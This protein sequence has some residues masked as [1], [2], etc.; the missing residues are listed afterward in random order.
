MPGSDPRNDDLTVD[1][2]LDRFGHAVERVVSELR[3][4]RERAGRMGQEYEAL[5]SAVAG[6]DGAGLSPD[7][8]RRLAVLADE[9]ARLR[10]TLEEARSRADRIR[11]RLAVVE[12]EI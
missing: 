1:A 2:L 3:E 10:A 5:R 8:E 6:S 11:A 9:N 4:A 7:V 12:D